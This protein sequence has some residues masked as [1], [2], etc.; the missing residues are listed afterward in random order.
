MNTH[1][2]EH[3]CPLCDKHKLHTQRDVEKWLN[4]GRATIDGWIRR[5][6]LIRTYVGPKLIRF[7]SED[8]LA[9]ISRAKKEVANG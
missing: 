5:D 1:E 2:C 8:V 3:G 9:L 7:T 4:V 6:I